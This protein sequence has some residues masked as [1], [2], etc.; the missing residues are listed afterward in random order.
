M[1]YE[2]VRLRVELWQALALL[3]TAS[4]LPWLMGLGGADD[5]GLGF[6]S[7]SGLLPPTLNLTFIQGFPVAYQNGM[8]LPSFELQESRLYLDLGGL[9]KAFYDEEADHMLSLASR[10]RDV[11]N[12]LENRGFHTL[13]FDDSSWE[14]EAI[15]CSNNVRGGR[16]EGYQGVVWYRRV[17]HVPETFKGM[18]VKLVFQGCNYIAD[19]WVNGEYMGYHEGGFTPFAFDVTEH[20]NYGGLN[21]LAVRVDNVP[22]ETVKTIVP[23][24]RC[25][26]WN[27]GG[28]YRE[29]YLEASPM[30]H[31]VRADATPVKAEEGYGFKVRVMV[32]NRWVS[33]V[34]AR[35]RLRVFEAELSESDM[36]TPFSSLLI[37]GEGGGPAEVC[38]TLVVK[39]GDVALA[40]EFLRIENPKFW[41]P[42]EPN[43]YVVVAELSSPMGVD[44][45][46]TQ[47]GLRFLERSGLNVLLNWEPLFLKGLA[48]HEDYPG[49]GRTVKPRDILRDLRLIKKAGANWVRTAHYPNHPLTYIYT[50]RLGLAVSE[51]IPVYWFDEEAYEIQLRR[52]AARQML[53][54]MVLRDYNRPSILFWSLGNEGVGCDARADFLRDLSKT[55]RLLDETRLITEAM[56]WNPW[57]DAWVRGGLDLPSFNLYFGVFYGSV[58]DL[59]YALEVF[60]MLNP[61]TPMLVTEF[62]IWSGGDVGEMGQVEYFEEAWKRIASKPYVVGVCWWT[63]FDYD[64]MLQFDTF[65]AVDWSR[66]CFKPLYHAIKEAYEASRPV[67]VGRAGGWVNRILSGLAVAVVVAAAGFIYHVRVK[68]LSSYGS[69]TQLILI[70]GAYLILGVLS[71]C[72]SWPLFIASSWVRQL[73]FAAL[74]LLALGILSILIGVVTFISWVR[75]RRTK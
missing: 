58:E 33:T 57:D 37:R 1:F 54:E 21:L 64:S 35:L 12:R 51:E 42:E 46:S 73:L 14:D 47:V 31:V 29:V 61:D 60:H 18:F 68:G 19:V 72:L 66:T 44:R 4:S 30:V 26:W 65:G 23:Y 71:I 48:R 40:E 53:I 63:A 8:P 7:T 16:H 55:L 13:D 10:S 70:A 28:I 25:D 62:G 20:L 52:C 49:T 2:A 6:V 59:D 34:E 22:W 56:V 50:D 69:R 17:F 5:G 27:Y 75:S 15:P 41:S 38:D 36:L 67:S 24:R 39:P 45:F 32:Y 43:L 3:L 74:I 11:L 9:W